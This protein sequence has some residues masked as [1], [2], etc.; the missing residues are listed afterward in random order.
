MFSREPTMITLTEKPIEAVELSSQETEMA[1]HSGQAIANFV[2]GDEYL[3]LTLSRETGEQIQAKIPARAVHLLAYILEE[4]AK[5]NPITLI[6]KHAELSTI[7]AAELMRVSRPYLVKLLEEG[8]IP[9]RL[10]GAH[11]RVRYDDLLE[12]IEQGKKARKEALKELIAE[13]ERLGLYE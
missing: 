10:V 1:R 5:G 13:Q 9:F 8:K 4:M 2:N 3:Y 12:Y 7:Q 11:R 6:S